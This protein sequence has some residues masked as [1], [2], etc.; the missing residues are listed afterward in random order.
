MYYTNKIGGNVWLSDTEIVVV[1]Y[2]EELD[3]NQNGQKLV[4]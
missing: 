4:D 2:D 3:L 1:A